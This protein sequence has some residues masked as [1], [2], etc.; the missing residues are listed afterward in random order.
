[1]RTDIQRNFSWYLFISVLF[2]A[3]TKILGTPFLV[4]LVIVG[5]V[6]GLGKS[7]I[8]S[9]A[10]FRVFVV[11][12]IITTASFLF[13]RGSF[14]FVDYGIQ[15]YLLFGSLAIAQRVP[16]IK[17]DSYYRFCLA[18]LSFL[19]CF[20]SLLRL[21]GMN[22]LDSTQLIL[23]YS[24]YH[25]IWWL[26]LLLVTPCLMTFSYKDGP[27][28]SSYKI[29]VICSLFLFL[30]LLLG[31]RTG[32]VMGF[33]LF[34]ASIYTWNKRITIACGSFLLILIL[35]YPTF[36]E[37][38][39]QAIS[40]DLYERGTVASVR[41]VIWSCYF[42]NLSLRDI[43][44][45][46]NKSEVAGN[47]L[48]AVGWYNEGDLY[49]KSESSFIGLLSATGIIGVVYVI[50]LMLRSLIKARRYKMHFALMLTLLV[51]ASSGDY[52]FFSIYDW[53]FFTLILGY[54]DV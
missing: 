22:S 40:T 7:F 36:I 43:L 29:L 17:T 14:E 37:T 23:P 34:L 11:F 1:M 16:R 19:I 33:F 18:L 4:L 30:S 44:V 49:V 13:R 38:V 46:F 53:V 52:L 3:T 32:V 50:Y 39:I 31:G 45:G 12:F 20:Y 6:I 51:R 41:S 26:C 35:N 9:K 8:L 25:M 42:D 10:L 48:L 21:N 15:L 28:Y 47:C 54:E 27:N 5:S 24:S 2:L